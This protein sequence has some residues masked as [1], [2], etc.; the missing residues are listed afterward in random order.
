ML[1]QRVR[2]HSAQVLLGYLRESVP[3]DRSCEA[4]VRLSVSS[5]EEICPL[6]IIY[7]DWTGNIPDV[8]H[9]ARG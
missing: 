5:K 1:L 8:P 3:L 7:F 4:A 6:D 9:S 2:Y